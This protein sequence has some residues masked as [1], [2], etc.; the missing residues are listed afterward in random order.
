MAKQT[1]KTDGAPVYCKAPVMVGITELRPNPANPN[2]HPE[3]QL[4]LIAKAL[5]EG[6][7]EPIT[8]SNRSGLIVRGHGRLMAAKAMGET[9][10]PVDYQDYESEADEMA[11]LVRD[12]QL[13]NMSTFD[14]PNL[15]DILET[16]DVGVMDMEMFGFSED[17]RADLAHQFF[18]P[19]LDPKF[20]AHNVTDAGVTKEAKRLGDRFTNNNPDQVKFECPHCGEAFYVRKEDA[21]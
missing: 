3:E 19:T 13:A 6:W 4:R 21:E 8:V 2:M 1:I 11:D 12:N 15:K 17:A 7:R 9:Q 5:K 10:V 18:V 14:L 20:N 16:Y